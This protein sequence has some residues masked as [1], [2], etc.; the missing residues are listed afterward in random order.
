MI[1][2]F[3]LSH[4]LYNQADPKSPTH[5]FLSLLDV[6]KPMASYA[7]TRGVMTLT[8]AYLQPQICTKCIPLCALTP[9][10]AH[11]PWQALASAE[12]RAL[13]P[14]QL[15]T[16]NCSSL[17]IQDGPTAGLSACVLQGEKCTKS[18]YFVF[19]LL[20]QELIILIINCILK[21]MLIFIPIP[22]GS[23]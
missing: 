4:L 16:N 15:V 12:Q 10:R 6:F 7:L 11:T 3:Y 23:F 5:I 14:W 19:F 1:D 2:T 20:V 21:G 17:D 18:H 9:G 22:C 8:W 13:E